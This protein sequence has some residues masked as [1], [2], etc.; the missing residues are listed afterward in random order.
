MITWNGLS[1]AI[2]THTPG[3]RKKDVF[4]RKLAGVALPVH[5]KT[6]T[7]T[8][9]IHTFILYVS[10]ATPSDAKTTFDLW[11]AQE[12]TDDNSATITGN[13]GA[14]IPNAF[15]RS[16]PKKQGKIVVHNKEYRLTFQ[17]EFEVTA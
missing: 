16:V 11:L 2:T 4:T 5:K 12:F 7:T 9:P 14:D 3:A 13:F 15:I 6:G 17:V 10:G 1:A 8:N